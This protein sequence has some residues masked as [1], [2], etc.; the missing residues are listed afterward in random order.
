MNTFAFASTQIPKALLYCVIVMSLCGCATL[1]TTG[2][3]LVTPLTG[4]RDV[5]DAPLVTIANATEGWAR[6]S[7]P[8]P[9]P[10]ATGGWTY[11]GGF[12]TGIGINFSYYIFK[13]LSYLFGGVDYAICR[14]IWPNFPDGISPWKRP[15]ESWWELYFPNTRTLW[16]PTY[17]P[18]GMD[19]FRRDAPTP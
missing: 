1:E 17:Q 13:G 8:R 10:Q 4:V 6:A 16:S 15:E 18:P 12:D 5:V 14:S 11:K 7:N 2:K 3:V 9:V 19:T